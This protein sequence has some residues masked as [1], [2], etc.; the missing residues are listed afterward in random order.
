MG[1]ALGA[2]TQG[3]RQMVMKRGL[4]LALSGRRRTRHRGPC[5]IASVRHSS[6][7]YKHSGSS[8]VPDYGCHTRKPDP[9]TESHPDGRC[10][11][12]SDCGSVRRAAG[13][14]RWTLGVQPIVG[15]AIRQ[16]GWMNSERVVAIPDRGTGIGC[17][18]G[19]S[20]SGP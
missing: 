16:H 15:R 9:G 7:P 11:A 4:L 5:C 8:A 18:G 6:G 1:M 3:V 2:D 12:R 17:S 14:W 19:L 20:T 13:W 10:C